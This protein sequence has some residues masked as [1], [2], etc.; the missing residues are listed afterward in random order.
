MEDQEEHRLPT[1]DLR[2]VLHNMGGICKSE[3][4]LDLTHLENKVPGRVATCPVSP[5]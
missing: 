4:C 2:I 5:F 1:V 3:G